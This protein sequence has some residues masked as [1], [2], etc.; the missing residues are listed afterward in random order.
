MLTFSIKIWCPDS[1]GVDAFS[2]NWKGENNWLVPPVYL[3]PKTILHLRFCRAE[4]SLVVPKWPSSPFWPLIFPFGAV[5][6]DIIEVLEFTNPLGIFQKGSVSNTIFGSTEFKS[7]VL[8]LRF[9]AQ[10]L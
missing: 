1:E 6:S 7:P 10:F 3:I 2:T 4:G 5:C 8:V 9:N